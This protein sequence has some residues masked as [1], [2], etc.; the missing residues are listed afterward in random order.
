VFKTLPALPY[1]HTAAFLGLLSSNVSHPAEVVVLQKNSRRGLSGGSNPT[2]T[3]SL[4]HSLSLSLS[5]PFH[6]SPSRAERKESA[7]VIFSIFAH[8]FSLLPPLA[9]RYGTATPLRND[10]RETGNWFRSA[11]ERTKAC[12]RARAVMRSGGLEITGSREEMK[13]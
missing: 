3:S 10:R 2:W 6:L 8:V 11:N 1:T 13:G 9:A 7:R 5:L 12:V 4:L